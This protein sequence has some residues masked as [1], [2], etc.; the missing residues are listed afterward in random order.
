[1]LTR[2]AEIASRTLRGSLGAFSADLIHLML[3]F[4]DR[5]LRGR[6]PSLRPLVSLLAQV[7]CIKNFVDKL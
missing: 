7:E 4:S 5:N 1:V 3:K 2:L 6:A